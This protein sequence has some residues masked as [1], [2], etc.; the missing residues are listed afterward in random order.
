MRFDESDPL[1][2]GCCAFFAE[3][4]PPVYGRLLEDDEN[5]GLKPVT[6][7]MIARYDVRRGSVSVPRTGQ[8]LP[9]F[10]VTVVSGT[11]VCADHARILAQPLFASAGR[12]GKVW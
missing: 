9:M 3:A 8:R 1:C 7:E 2:A 5:A 4:H 11:Y 12:T 6:L 10:A